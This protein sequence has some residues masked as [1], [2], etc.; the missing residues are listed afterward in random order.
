MTDQVVGLADQ[1]V[2]GETANGDKCIVAV[3]DTA[4][5][6]GCGDQPLFV[7]KGSFIFGNG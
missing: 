1:F 5:E 4:V 3:G 6:I 7:G 2:H